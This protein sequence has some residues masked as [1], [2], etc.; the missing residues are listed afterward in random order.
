MALF[1][2]CAVPN[3]FSMA[4]TPQPNSFTR[5]SLTFHGQESQ[6]GL[7]VPSRPIAASRNL[8]L[9]DRW[10]SRIGTEL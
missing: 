8:G 3:A 9:A 6:T 5:S 7:G 2:G 4:L 1:V 10:V